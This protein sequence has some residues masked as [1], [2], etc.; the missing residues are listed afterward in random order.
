MACELEDDLLFYVLAGVARD[1]RVEIGDAADM[2]RDPVFA[3]ALCF[4]GLDHWL[5]EPA[6][7]ERMKHARGV[8]EA[9][10]AARVGDE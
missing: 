10:R 9:M 3:A 8:I 1:R 4:L 6:P 7:E 2:K 5:D